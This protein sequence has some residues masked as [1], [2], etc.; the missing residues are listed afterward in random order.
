MRNLFKSENLNKIIQIAG[1]WFVYFLIFFTTDSLSYAQ[2]KN[3]FIIVTILV[4]L[5]SIIWALQIKKIN[6]NES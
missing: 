1:L 6:R 4:V 3:G 5:V 2:N